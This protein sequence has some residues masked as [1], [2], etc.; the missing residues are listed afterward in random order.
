MR[1]I[2]FIK[3]IVKFY[4]WFQNSFLTRDEFGYCSNNAIIEY[5][6]DISYKENVQ[7]YDNARIRKGAKFIIGPNEKVIIKKYTVLAPGV[8]IVTQN[9]TS[10]VTI[11][12]CLLGLS[13]INDKSGDVII[14]ED[15]WVGTNVTIL[16]GVTIG[17]GAI[18]AAGS[19]VSR[20]VPPYAL[21]AGSPAKILKKKF[22]VEQILK[23]EAAIYAPNE[24]MSREELEENNVRYFENKGTFG[25]ETGLTADHVV[26]LNSVK[27]KIGYVN[28]LEHNKD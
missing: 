27:S 14:E 24:R 16:A 21:V 25:L 8:T 10:T 4:R 5:P 26:R 12:Q 28:P 19:I 6:V 23:H 9:H 11:P 1:I 2:I 13:H 17:R 22:T 7:L 18:I 20:D 15:V 3:K